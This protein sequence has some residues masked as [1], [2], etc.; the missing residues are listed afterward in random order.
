MKV[1]VTGGSGLIGSTIVKQLLDAN[2][3]VGIFDIKQ[4]KH[5]NCNFFEGDITDSERTKEVVKDHDVVIHL[6][7][8]LG[9]INTETNPVKTLDTNYVA[10]YYPWVKIDDPSDGQGLWVPPSV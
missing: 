5:D 8:T 4:T 9:V 7:A 10:T 3:E 1:L 6:A 2:H